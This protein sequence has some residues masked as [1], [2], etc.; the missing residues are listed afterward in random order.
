MKDMDARDLVNFLVT[1][2]IPPL[3]VALKVGFG[4]HFWVN[5]ALTVF[6][7]Y[8]PGLIHGLWV[9]LKTRS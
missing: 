8:L 6:G 1:I 9:V 7:F 4:L 2:F 3:G 5:L